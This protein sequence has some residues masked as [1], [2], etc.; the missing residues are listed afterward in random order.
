MPRF[1]LKG[2]YYERNKEARI[3]AMKEYNSREEV[4]EHRKKINK[5]YY[6]RRKN[7]RL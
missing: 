5:E 3:K 7:A 4:K 6:Q 1:K 2:T